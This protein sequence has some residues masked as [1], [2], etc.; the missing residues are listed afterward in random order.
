MTF[1]DDGHN[2]GRPPAEP[3]THVEDATT[4]VVDC[5]GANEEAA[6]PGESRNTHRLF[7]EAAFAEYP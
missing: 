7:K 6:T 4:D 1:S 3:I 2:Q 5:P